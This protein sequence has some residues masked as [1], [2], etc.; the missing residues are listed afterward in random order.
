MSIHFIHILL[1]CMRVPFPSLSIPFGVFYIM[2][3]P[4]QLR[5]CESSF[6][7]YERCLWLCVYVYEL[8]MPKNKDIVHMNNRSSQ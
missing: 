2:Y 3:S 8:H 7:L 4:C 1:M 5:L 6:A